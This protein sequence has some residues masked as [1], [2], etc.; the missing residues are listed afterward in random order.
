MVSIRQRVARWLDPREERSL[1]SWDLLRAHHGGVGIADAAGQ[2]V[3]WRSAEHALATVASCVQG[4]A[5]ALGMLPAYVYRW[6]GERRL[7]APTNPLQRLI[8]RGPNQH[9][10]WADWVEWTMASALLRGNALSEIVTNGAGAILEL[11]PISWDM[12]SVVELPGDRIAYDV[13]NERTGGTRRLLM[14]EVYHLRDRTDDGRIGVSRIQRHAGV[15]GSAQALA[16]FTGSM[17]KN[18]I[19]PSGAIELDGKLSEPGFEALQ[20]RWRRLYSGPSNA[21]RVVILDQAAKFK[22]ISVSPED[23]ELLESRK[24][25]A[26]DICRIFGVPPIMAQIWD[27]ASFTNSEQASRWYATHTL[28][29]WA[30]KIQL[31]AKRTLLGA[32]LEL[33]LDASDLL[34]GS[35]L[36]RWQAN[37]L[38]VE[39]GV[40]DPDEIRELENWP[41]RASTPPAA[42]A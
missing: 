30:R 14:E 12:V 22:P 39:S 23:A 37:K 7:L 6:D 38:A 10:S 9:Q 8:D 16:E 3:S 2:V 20:E 34:R 28:G 36:E 29:P 17:W 24:F 15:L 40:L 26:V 21:A 27:S 5:S 32:N 31:E 11:R 41:P 13:A 19:S 4:I 33:T 1:T 42:A 25:S 35:H 18:G